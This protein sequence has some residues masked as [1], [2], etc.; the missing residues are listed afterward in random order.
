MDIVMTIAQWIADN[1]FGQPAFMIGIVALIGLIVQ[2]KTFSQVITGTMK[3]IVGFLIIVAGTNIVVSALLT[4]TPILQAAFGFTDPAIPETAIGLDQMMAQYGSVAALIMAFGFLFHVLLARFTK[5][6]YIYLTG[7]LMFW[8]ALVLTTIMI[9][10]NPAA[11]QWKIVL[12]G[13][14]IAGIYWTLQPAVTQPMMRKLTGN[15]TLAYGHTSASSSWLSAQIAKLKPLNKPEN[16]TEDMNLPEGLSFFRD[17]TV[18]TAFVI[19]IVVLVASFFAG[20]ETMVGLAGGVDPS[21][22]SVLQGFNFAVGIGIMLYGVRMI[23]G[24]IIPAFRGI[25]MKVVPGAVPALDC[26]IIF[27]YAPTAVIFGFLAT[28]ATFLV[29]MVIFGATGFAV[30]IPPMIMIFFV[31]APAGVF[32]NAYGGVRGA[33]V[34]GLLVGL[35]LAFGQAITAPML[36]H[37]APEL[38]QLADPDWYLIIWIFK[39]LLSLIL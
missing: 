21:I 27:D 20:R 19:S 37:T 3:T 26:P 31:G 12:I 33:L 2:R 29:C 18:A 14:I 25:A 15:D 17:V 16:S 36:A 34:G 28:F 1:I 39:P 9:E 13:S 6:K 8:I 32:G 35:W 10:I 23:L 5:F 30:I 11:P 22:F 24:E 7:H 38:A 4:F